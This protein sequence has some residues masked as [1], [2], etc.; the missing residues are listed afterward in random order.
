MTYCRG[1][2]RSDLVVLNHVLVKD[3]R[4]YDG[5]WLLLYALSSFARSVKNF[6]GQVGRWTPEII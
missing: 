1:L 6:T 3:C 5:D 4:W 2:L